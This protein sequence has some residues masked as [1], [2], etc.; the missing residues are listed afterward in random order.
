MLGFS[1]YLVFGESFAFFSAS[2]DLLNAISYAGLIIGLSYDKITRIIPL[3]VVLY[4]V[5]PC[6]AQYRFLDGV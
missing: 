5:A 2:N 4:V 3:F 1:G 6:I